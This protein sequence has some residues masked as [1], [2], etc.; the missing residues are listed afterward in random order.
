MPHQLVESKNLKTQFREL[1][2]EKDSENYEQ[3]AVLMAVLFGITENVWNG[4]VITL[5]I[6]R[7]KDICKLLDI[8]EEEV[9]EILRKFGQFAKAM[10]KSNPMARAFFGEDP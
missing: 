4:D 5:A 2:G 9:N 1:A 6:Y 8:P 7:A 10:R 3:I